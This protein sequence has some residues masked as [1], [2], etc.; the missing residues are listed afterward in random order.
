MMHTEIQSRKRMLFRV[1]PNGRA[2]EIA[3]RVRKKDVY[4]WSF[5]HGEEILCP[6]P[7]SLIYSRPLLINPHKVHV[8]ILS[9]IWYL[10]D[11]EWMMICDNQS[12]QLVL[13]LRR[14]FVFSH[15]YRMSQIN[16]H[17]HL[18][19]NWTWDVKHLSL[20]KMICIFGGIK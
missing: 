20:S 12:Q 5:C 14:L 16:P 15:P 10:G 7:D 1:Y 18:H 6:P 9:E 13:L 19:I 2:F 17:S 8:R 11:S 4:A 3:M